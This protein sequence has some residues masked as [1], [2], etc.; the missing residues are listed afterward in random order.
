MFSLR[1]LRQSRTRGGILIMTLVFVTMFVT[2]FLALSGFVSQSYHQAVLQSQD[3]VAFQI[4]E[5]GLNFARWRLAHS[6]TDFS[7][8]TKE[9]TDQYA[10][11]L[12]SYTVTFTAPTPGSTVVIL[13]SVGETIGHTE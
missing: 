6:P 3:E 4:A 11:V 1:L 5:A 8:V 7:S 10:G 13:T 12:G 2:I 9:I